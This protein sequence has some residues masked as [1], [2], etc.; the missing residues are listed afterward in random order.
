MVFGDAFDGERL[1]QPAAPYP[2]RSGLPLGVRGGLN[3]FAFWS[4]QV[5]HARFS[6]EHPAMIGGRSGVCAATRS[7]TANTARA[8][9]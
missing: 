1:R 7:A 4:A 9:P 2:W 3:D 5:C 8:L 6:V